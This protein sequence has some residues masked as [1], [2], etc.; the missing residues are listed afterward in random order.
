MPTNATTR[1]PPA[2]RL[3]RQ[4]TLCL[5]TLAALACEQTAPSSDTPAG[6]QVSKADAK[7]KTSAGDARQGADI[8]SPDAKPPADATAELTAFRARLEKMFHALPP[9]E[10]LERP[11]ACPEFVAPKDGS[12]KIPVIDRS[13]LQFFATGRLRRPSPPADTKSDKK[14]A[15]KKSADNKPADNKP[16]AP[17]PTMVDG[18]SPLSSRVLTDLRSLDQ[19][20][21]ER[22]AA[23]PTHAALQAELAKLEKNERL[24]VVLGDLEPEPPRGEHFKG[25]A[26]RGHVVFYNLSSGRPFCYEPFTAETTEKDASPEAAAAVYTELVTRTRAAVDAAVERQIP[27]LKVMWPSP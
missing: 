24:L 20:E 26:Y 17:V 1:P 7:T 25:G 27:G 9:P 8:K 18:L 11:L 4:L 21:G 12:M 14:S 22:P 15:A 13:L 3:A 23:A 10:A 2:A 6:D 19:R 16:A 5:T